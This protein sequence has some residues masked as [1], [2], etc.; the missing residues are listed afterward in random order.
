MVAARH[1]EEAGPHCAQVVD[2][3]RVPFRLEEFVGGDHP[4]GGVLRT[5]LDVER[6]MVL[7]KTCGQYSIS[8]RTS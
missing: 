6:C 8:T 2:P 1:C 3:H 4:L 7:S 5:G